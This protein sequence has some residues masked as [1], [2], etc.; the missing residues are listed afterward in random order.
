MI[1]WLAILL[2]ALALHA[3]GPFAFDET[4]YVYS[5][6]RT[7]ELSGTIRFDASGMEIDYTAPE[8][9]RIVYDGERLRTFDGEGTLQHEIDLNDEP[10]MRLYMQFLLWLYRGDF[11]AL[12]AYFTVTETPEGMR[13]DPI[14]PTDRVVTSVAVAGS[15]GAI[16]QI[17]TDMSNGDAITIRISR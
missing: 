10:G 6:D 8:A 7:L 11:D 13:L 12:G 16:R 15:A 17:Q 14:P 2:V 3:D 5:I 1:R 4:R 9:S